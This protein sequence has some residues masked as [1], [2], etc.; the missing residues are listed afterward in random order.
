[1]N[2]ETWLTF[3]K[4]IGFVCD[5]HVWGLRRTVGSC[6][7]LEFGHIFSTGTRK[8]GSTFTH[9]ERGLLITGGFWRFLINSELMLACEDSQPKID[10][11]FKRLADAQVISLTVDNNGDLFLETDR[12]LLIVL[13]MQTE[14]TDYSPWQ[15]RSG[16]NHWHLQS[17][18]SLT[19]E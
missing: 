3:R 10:A 6:F 18:G 7:F 1:M 8:D 2:G 13:R 17:D 19:K 9:G 16:S 14:L 5:T 15:F 11:A 4:E 12:W